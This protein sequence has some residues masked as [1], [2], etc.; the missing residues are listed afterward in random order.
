M[1]FLKTGASTCKS[2]LNQFFNLRDILQF[3]QLE[4]VIPA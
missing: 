4:R 1:E 3:S 2:V